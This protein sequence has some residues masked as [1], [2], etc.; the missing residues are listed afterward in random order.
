[1]DIPRFDNLAMTE[2]VIALSK[3]INDFVLERNYDHHDVNDLKC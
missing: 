3:G 1:M 2:P